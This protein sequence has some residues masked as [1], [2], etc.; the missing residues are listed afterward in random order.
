MKATVYLTLLWLFSALFL[1]HANE[2][3]NPSMEGTFYFYQDPLG[4][5]AEAWTGFSESSCYFSK[6][7]YAHDGSK[8]QEIIWNGWGYESFGVDGI[9]QQ[10]NNLQ[11]GKSYMYSAWFK[12]NFYAYGGVC[13]IPGFV[14]GNVSITCGIGADANGGTDY[15][16]V[17]NWSQTTEDGWGEWYE[18]SWINITSFFSTNVTTPTIF[19]KLDGYGD[20][21]EECEDPGCPDPPC[22]YP[23]PAPWDAYCCLDDVF[24]Q[25]MEVGPTARSKLLRRC[26]PMV[27]AI[28]WLQLRFWIP[29][30]IQL[31]IFQFR[32]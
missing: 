18:G 8:S 24:V 31:K 10:L 3:N 21:V 4:D 15:A 30:T 14:N 12:L 25:L 27:P 7:S 2:V 5:V 19:I 6:G 16:A 9:Y 29:A 23:E 13:P 22:F 28:V 1:A 11:P 17:S 20:A 26:L 32:K